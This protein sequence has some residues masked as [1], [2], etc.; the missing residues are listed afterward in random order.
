[1][2]TIKPLP[3][4]I[5]IALSTSALADTQTQS[6]KT[7]TLDKV[8]VAATLTEQSIND[9]ANTVNII[10][11]DAIEHQ[12]STNVR[13]LLKYEPGIEVAQAGRFGLTSVNV[14]GT[15]RNQVKIVIDGVDQAKVLDNSANYFQSS[16]R[17]FVDMDSL[18]Q[19]EVVKGP[20]SSLYGS[21]AIGGVVAFTTKDPAD[22]LAAQGD[23]TAATIKTGYTSANNGKYATLSLANRTGN[24]ETLLVYTDR[25]SDETENYDD[26]LVGG[27]GS[28]RTKRDPGEF[29]SDNLLF[30]AQYQ[31]T[32]AHR[33]GLTVENF[34]SDSEEDILSRYSSIYDN[35]VADNRSERTRISIE[36]DWDAQLPIF[37]TLQ[38]TLSQ[39]NTKTNHLTREDVNI[40]SYLSGHFG[41]PPF[42]SLN[43]A[44][45]K[46]YSYE[47]DHLQLTSYFSKNLGNHLI[48][49]GL[50]Y[51]VTEFENETN[52]YYA[53]SP[54]YN[55]E[56]RYV[57][58]IENTTY[59]FFVQD[60]ITLLE[61]KLILTPSVRYDNFSAKVKADAGFPTELDGHD[62]DK[63]SL[64]IGAVYDFS[65][66]VTG[67]AQY[68]QGF[69]VPDLQ[70]MYHTRNGGTYLN[71]AN[72]DL[73]AEESDS[74]EIGLRYQTKSGNLEVTAFYNDYE[75]YIGSESIGTQY[76]GVTYTNGVTRPI[77]IADATIKG[78]EMRGSLWLDEALGAPT[79]TSLEVAV[80][81][82]HG[83]GKD[84]KA[85]EDQPLES[86][87]PLKGVIGLNYDAPN[88]RWGGTLDWTLVDNKKASD[89]PDE[90]DYASAGYGLLDL[91]A[92]FNVTDNFIVRANL[93]NLTDKK[94]FIYE[95]VRGISA[96]SSTIDRHSQPG[97]NFNINATYTF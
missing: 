87:A 44:R 64:R 86:I 89:L 11:A 74:Y 53:N 96:N 2:I 93:N 10:D 76:D 67:F 20:A 32:E 36:H 7:F 68:A 46:D 65:D 21:N 14:R 56:S 69:K 26:H 75:N 23:D 49:Y 70:D 15:D 43:D 48:G 57:P 5:A 40:P 61:D 29:N 22:Y 82:A 79:G 84:N 41:L 38:W 92:Y 27:T 83:E 37:D 58:K 24:L 13:E 63:V 6:T 8:T 19:V 80:A 16:G 28:S 54:Q 51:E 18:K 59:G 25:N 78:I 94:Y 85:A 88:S 77:N 9:V 71:L 3:L 39:Q 81:Y 17:L 72:P 12:G 91:N 35:S 1:M 45:S 62:S 66:K 52:T 90:T 33:F 31:L 60:Q 34:N 30:K 47:E 50:N 73:E 55:D 4:A 95:D 97:R 42:T